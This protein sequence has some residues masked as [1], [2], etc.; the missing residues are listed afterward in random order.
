MT[1]FAR[2]GIVFIAQMLCVVWMTLYAP[3][4]AASKGTDG[5]V[6]CH[7]VTAVKTYDRHL[8]SDWAGSVH[9]KRGVS[10]EACHA[11]DPSQTAKEAAHVGVY[12][13]GDPKSTVYF[14]NVPQTC[15]EKCH[16]KEYLNFIKSNHFH[17][18]EAE[19]KGP[20]CV[21]CHGSMAISIIS[22]KK[23]EGLCA[24]CHNLRMGISPTRPSEARD[25]LLLME[26]TRTVIHWAQE[27][28]N[29]ARAASHKKRADASERLLQKARVEYNLA[30]AGWHT[31][32]VEKLRDSLREAY[33]LARS[34]RE[35]LKLQ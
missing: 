17:K 34:A 3:S 35:A 32:E 9:A 11:G 28:T 1:R 23:M 21:T 27:F 14:K 25:I 2:E 22:E 8:F 20:N 10:C 26:Q 31:F 30:Q 6:N 4:Q 13:S 12:R 5:C 33:R 29:L 24:N 19:G 16:P 15:G 18:L 7:K